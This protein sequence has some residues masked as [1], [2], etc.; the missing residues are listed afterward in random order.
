MARL[1]R[2]AFPFSMIVSSLA[3][4]ALSRVF[5][6][7]FSGVKLCKNYFLI[8]VAHTQNVPE[9]LKGRFSN[10]FSRGCKS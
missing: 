8:T 6:S 1:N 4:D 3:K 7:D 5:F 9:K 2:V 10:E